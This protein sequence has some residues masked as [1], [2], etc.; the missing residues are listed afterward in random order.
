M[1]PALVV[2]S[3]AVTRGRAMSLAATSLNVEPGRPLA[4]LGRNG[5]GKS[6]LLGAI[7]GIVP[8]VS[9]SVTVG[10]VDVTKRSADERARRGIAL[11]AEGRRLFPQM[12]VA[13]NLRLGGFTQGESSFAA[14]SKRVSE[15]FPFLAERAGSRAGRL[16]GGE[17]QM[18]VIGRALM[19]NPQ[20]LLLDEPSL[21][22]APNVIAAVY[23]C[24]Q[25]LS[26]DGLAI[27]LV[28]QQ[29]R[30]ALSFAAEGIVL[31]R[32]RVV[33][34]DSAARLKDD[35]RLLQAYMGR[36]PT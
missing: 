22:L 34:R 27:V 9:G 1:K 14:A 23:D 19:A 16:S 33:A 6:T 11:V 5:A 36:R 35:P 3:L 10:D 8:S 26:R 32:G 18:L 12:T 28:E 2:E 29:V 4:V 17:Q 15:L 30:R 24:L 13:E 21:G 25:K 7:A 20:V 31:N